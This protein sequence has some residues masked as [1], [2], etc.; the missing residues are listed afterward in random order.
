M[1]NSAHEH[2]HPSDPSHSQETPIRPASRSLSAAVFALLVAGAAL[3]VDPSLIAQTLPPA[4]AQ[5][6]LLRP[7]LPAAELTG[8]AYSSSV[9]AEDATPETP[10]VTDEE[11]AA[12]Q[13]SRP[14]DKFFDLQQRSMAPFHRLGVAV[15]AGTEAAGLEIATSLGNHFNLRA[16]GNYFS[17]DLNFNEEGYQVTGRII[18]R[19][20]NLGLDYYPFRHSGFRISP[21][22]VLDNGNYVNGN[23]VIPCGESF[24]LGDAT[25]TSGSSTGHGCTQPISGQVAIAFDHQVAPSLTLGWGNIIPRGRHHWSVP[26]ELGFEYTGAPTVN[27]N[28]QGFACDQYN[29]CE[30]VVTDPA[31]QANVQAERT[32]INNDLSLL[33]FYPLLSIG[34]GW[35]W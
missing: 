1:C 29:D 12:S 4:S 31:T 34:F 11:L 28:I 7:S 25:Y 10:I 6:D 23:I 20:A 5:A 3:F 33:R 24:D 26:F 13:P 9:V 19:F 35:S 22:V 16:T 21:G 27:F 15:T 18:T 30:N 17:Y 2:P 32:K 8:P 14:N